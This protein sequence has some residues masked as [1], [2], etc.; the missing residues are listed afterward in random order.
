MNPTLFVKSLNVSCNAALLSLDCCGNA[1][2]EKLW[3]KDSAQQDALTF[4]KDDATAIF[5]NNDGINIP[6]AALKSYLL[7]IYDD[8]EDGQI[9]IAEADN[10][11]SVNCSG[12]GVADL[13]GLECCTKLVTVNCANNSIAEID[14]HTLTQLRTINCAGNPVRKLVLD[15]CA[16]L[17]NL[18][19]QG[20]TTNAINGTTVSFSAYT[21]ATTFDFSIRNT[22]FTGFTFKDTPEL[23]SLVFDG[24]FTSVDI[25]GNTAVTSVDLSLLTGL[26][27]LDAHSCGLQSLDVTKNLALESLDCSGDS[28]PLLNVVNNTALGTLNCSKNNLTKINVTA[29]TAL[30][31]FDISGNGLS[32]INLRS[33][34]ALK[35]LNVSGNKEISLV[36]LRNNTLLEEL[37][38]SGLSISELDLTKIKQIK[39]L[40]IH[41][42]L[43]L[44]HVICPSR[45]WLIN[46]DTS[47]GIQETYCITGDGQPASGGCIEID[48]IIW[49]CANVGYSPDSRHGEKYSFYDAQRACPNGWRTPSNEELESLSTNYSAN[50]IFNGMNGRWFSGSNNY[51]ELTDAVFFPYTNDNSSAGSYW[52]S[53]SYT[54][55]YNVRH[56]QYLILSDSNKYSPH[57]DYIDEYGKGKCSVRCVK[58]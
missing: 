34:T 41:N 37:Y 53:N 46:T 19:L 14:L 55:S 12:K 40:D 49:S 21:Q 39:I 31:D 52:S 16:A 9:S 47:I 6:D 10:I 7:N 50:S 54:N 48:G 51:S 35:K 36:D 17:Q 29:N 25:S 1:S 13:T 11:I 18:L 42:N 26:T 15:N 32:A 56:Y 24:D 4:T 3:L 45:G 43:I 5:F 20:E 27:R 22:P 23:T 2:L 38:A 33:N 30:E 28:I 8:D 57:I 58:D 44:A